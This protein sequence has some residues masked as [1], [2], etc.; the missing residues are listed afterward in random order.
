MN[1]GKHKSTNPV[2]FLIWVKALVE[3]IHIH[4]W[5]KIGGPVR[6]ITEAEGLS[7]YTDG[8]IRDGE[9]TDITEVNP[10]WALKYEHVISKDV[11]AKAT[12]RL[13]LI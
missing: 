9:R 6:V 4:R 12:A 8:F 2:F 3:V 5:S 10:S 7:G 13:N 11:M 1:L